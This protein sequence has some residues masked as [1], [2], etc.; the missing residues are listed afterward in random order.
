MSNL[1]VYEGYICKEALDKVDVSKEFRDH[2][3][4]L[5]IS[6]GYD[7]NPGNVSKITGSKI[8]GGVKLSVHSKDYLVYENSMFINMLELMLLKNPFSLPAKYLAL[9]IYPSLDQSIDF[10]HAIQI[11]ENF[12]KNPTS[13]SLW[14]IREFIAKDKFLNDHLYEIL[15]N[16]FSTCED[17]IKGL[18]RMFGFSSTKSV[19][20]RDKSYWI[21]EFT[22]KSRILEIL[23]GCDE[24]QEK[25][26]C[27]WTE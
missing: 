7:P 15:V 22:P 2:T 24:L 10:S 9:F 6:L 20:Y 11:A 5:L 25:E 14:T 13:K 4:A 3:R 18:G 27:N 8:I 26:L 23:Q 21:L 17:G 19:I 16:E 1:G 12:R